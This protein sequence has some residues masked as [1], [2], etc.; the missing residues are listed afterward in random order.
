VIDIEGDELGEAHTGGEECFHNSAVA[1]AVRLAYV[2]ELRHCIDFARIE[3][4]VRLVGFVLRELN[5]GEGERVDVA[6]GEELKKSPKGSQVK[7]L[8]P[9]RKIGA[10]GRPVP[11]REIEAVVPEVLGAELFRR[12]LLVALLLEPLEEDAQDL[13]AVSEGTFGS[14]TYAYDAAG[15]VTQQIDPKNQTVN[16]TYDVLNRKLTEDYTGQ[17]GTEVSYTYDSCSNGVGRLCVASS[18]SAKITNA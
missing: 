11:A 15:N 5:L 3:E 1:Y 13:H 14:T 8:G 10:D 9:L 16:Y 6:L 17:S 4:R 7:I 18:T 2:W 12:Q